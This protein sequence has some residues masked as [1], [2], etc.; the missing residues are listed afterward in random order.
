MPWPMAKVLWLCHE[1]GAAMNKL[2]L[3]GRSTITIDSAQCAAAKKQPRLLLPS[4][5]LPADCS[6]V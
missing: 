6:G 4:V 3:L 1:Y 2:V 5:R